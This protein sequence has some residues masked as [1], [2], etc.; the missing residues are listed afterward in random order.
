MKAIVRRSGR[1]AEGLFTSLAKIAMATAL[2]SFI[3]RMPNDIH[4]P[5]LGMKRAMLVHTAAI[6]HRLLPHQTFL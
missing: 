1:G 6:F 2:P 3:E 5:E 4:H